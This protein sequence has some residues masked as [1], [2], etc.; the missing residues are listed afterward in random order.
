MGLAALALV[1]S[2]ALAGDWP[3]MVLSGGFTAASHAVVAGSS[4]ACRE[5][6]RLPGSGAAH[7]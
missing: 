2:S 1:V 6:A 7:A 4:R 3:L 5:C